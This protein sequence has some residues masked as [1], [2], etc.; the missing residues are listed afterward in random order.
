M[1]A[2]VSIAS[3]Y[4][5]IV[6]GFIAKK[7]FSDDINDK[8]LILISIYFLQPILTF[9]GLTRVELN[10]NLIYTPFLY[11]IIVTTLLL[12]SI[13]VAKKISTDSKE[14]SIFIAASLIGNTGNLGIPLGIALFGTESVAYTSMI[15]IANIFFIYTIGIYFYARSS[16]NIKNSLKNI[17]KIPILWFALL[18]I[19]YNYFGFSIH[20]QID[21]L[22]EMGAYS[23]IVLQLL[24]FGI[25]LSG[26]KIQTINYKLTFSSTF[27][28]L[29]LLPFVGYLFLVFLNV[30][31]FIASI[32]IIQ[33]LVPLAVNNVNIASLYDC[34]PYDVTIIV[35]L[36]SL[37][38]IPILFFYMQFIGA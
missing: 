10:Y 8:T 16:F 26:V 1:E 31:K 34:K 17:F 38:F 9:W 36:S 14:Q 23:A 24:I 25:Y 18:A 6:L 27:I 19:I 7:V 3:V 37:L 5:F 35:I 30:D 20:P 29:I 12:F 32:L 4:F 22:L 11:F 33:L 13:A 2:L 15:N 21:M 28:K